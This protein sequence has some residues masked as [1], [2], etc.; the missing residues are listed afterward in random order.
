MLAQLL[1]LNGAQR[2]TLTSNKGIKMETA[3]RLECADE[4]AELDRENAD[5]QWETLKKDN[6]YGFDVVVSA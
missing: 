3:R 6:T 5:E 1:K 4:Y 2:V